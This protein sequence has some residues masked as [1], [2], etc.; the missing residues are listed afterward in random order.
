M[1]TANAINCVTFGE[2]FHSYIWGRV[3]SPLLKSYVLKFSRESLDSMIFVSLDYI[4]LLF[5]PRS[6]IAVLQGD[7]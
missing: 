5:S 4:L 6:L 3:V 1:L 2:E 7:W